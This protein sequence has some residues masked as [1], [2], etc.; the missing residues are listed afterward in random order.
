MIERWG[1]FVARR[2]LAVLLAGLAVAVA[3][4]AYG[5]GVFDSLSQ[6]GFDDKSSESARELKLEQDT[7]GN[8]GI[9]VVAIY[10]SDDLTADDPAFQA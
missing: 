6:G 8:Q 2:S 10:S 5:F 9:D 1:A 7:F 4:A 3:A